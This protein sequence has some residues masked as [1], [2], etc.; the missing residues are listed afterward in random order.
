MGLLNIY[1]CQK[2]GGGSILFWEGK[3]DSVNVIYR[4]LMV[5]CI[6]REGVVDS[7]GVTQFDLDEIVD[8]SSIHVI[9]N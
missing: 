3:V 7:G 1:S 9:L 2:G 4:C 8:Q 6:F 5:G